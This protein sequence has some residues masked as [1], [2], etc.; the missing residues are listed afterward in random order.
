ME[1]NAAENVT[2]SSARLSGSIGIVSENCEIPLGAQRGFVYATS[3]MPNI[4]D[5][6]ISVN[7]G[8]I[9]ASLNGLNPETTYYVRTFIAN[10]IGKYYGNE[11]NFTTTATGTN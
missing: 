1:T 9:S 10:S 2:A 4:D 6:L 7:A 5:N 8:D 11:I 3:S